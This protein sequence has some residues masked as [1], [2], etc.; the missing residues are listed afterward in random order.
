LTNYDIPRVN[1][2]AYAQRLPE[3]FTQGR[4]RHDDVESGSNRTLSVVFVRKRVAEKDENSIAYE[5]RDAA[6]V[7]FDHLG[8]DSLIFAREIIQFFGV[9]LSGQVGGPDKVTEENG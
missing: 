4:N 8:T 5:P 7:T 3:P 2:H 1:R 6:F 9:E